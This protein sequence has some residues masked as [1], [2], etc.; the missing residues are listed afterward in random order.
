VLRVEDPF[1]YTDTRSGRTGG[2]IIPDALFDQIAYS[3]PPDPSLYLLDPQHQAIY[4][5]SL[6]L[7]L[8]RQYRALQPLAEGAATSFAISP[9]RLA[10]LAI[11]NQVYY[12][13]LP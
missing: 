12:A 6:R 5:F 4:H 10:F 9:T 1:V 8:D 3:P 13:A 11:G 7:N 2:E